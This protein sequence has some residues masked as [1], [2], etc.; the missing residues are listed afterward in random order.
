[1]QT[2]V[3]IGRC[4]ALISLFYAIVHDYTALFVTHTIIEP[5]ISKLEYI[6]I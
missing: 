1:M 5:E 2:T 3:V 4:D 6:K